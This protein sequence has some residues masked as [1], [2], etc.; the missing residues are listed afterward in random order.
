MPKITLL[1]YGRLKTKL[2]DS[3]A[4]ALITTLNYLSL[5][6]TPLLVPLGCS[7]SFNCRL[8]PPLNF[9]ELRALG[10]SVSSSSPHPKSPKTD[11]AYP[12]KAE[13]RLSVLQLL[14]GLAAE[15]SQPS[16]SRNRSCLTGIPKIPRPLHLPFWGQEASDWWMQHASPAF[17]PQLGP[18][19]KGHSDSRTIATTLE[20]QFSLS[21]GHLLHSPA[22]VSPKSTS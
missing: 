1:A 19:P 3:R 16:L 20:S 13:R 9:D 11:E 17:Q 21:P 12:Q 10:G 18:T 2:P 6:C 15:G 22:S 8:S 14:E 5:G 4:L 7:M